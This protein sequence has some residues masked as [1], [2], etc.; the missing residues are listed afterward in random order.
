V[1][2]GGLEYALA[3]APSGDPSARHGAC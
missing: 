1:G 2:I 3:A